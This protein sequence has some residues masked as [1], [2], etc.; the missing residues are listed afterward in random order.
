MCKPRELLLA[1][2]VAAVLVFAANAAGDGPQNDRADGKTERDILSLIPSG[3][4]WA[5]TGDMEVALK[6]QV[7]AKIIGDRTEWQKL[8]TLI[9][10][11]RYVP[12][13]V[14]K[15]FYYFEYPDGTWL[16]TIRL[17]IPWKT[18][19]NVFFDVTEAQ[20]KYV[21]KKT[22]REHEVWS[23]VKLDRTPVSLCYLLDR[24]LFVSNSRLT[25]LDCID[26]K[27]SVEGAESIFADDALRPYISEL[28]RGRLAYLVYLRR[29]AAAEKEADAKTEDRT[30]GL[31]LD[32]ES[33]IGKLRTLEIWIRAEHEN[34]FTGTIEMSFLKQ[35]AERKI[36]EFDPVTGKTVAVEYVEKVSQ[37]IQRQTAEI[38]KRFFAAHPATAE[39]FRQAL[40]TYTQ[41]VKVVI[42]APFDHRHL[43]PLSL[44]A[45][46]LWTKTRDARIVFGVSSRKYAGVA[47][48]QR[49][50]RPAWDGS[51]TGAEGNRPGRTLRPID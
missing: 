48:I 9:S 26:L 11:Y 37:E 51:D 15:R 23:G 40:L 36:V 45:I 43:A 39:Y 1:A 22:V 50:H 20:N 29:N 28:S 5:A 32:P 4:I 49:T 35:D 12:A 44:D 21:T 25:I 13:E 2:G 30:P 7:L 14:A 17:E 31:F 3:A 16:F 27:H 47:P 8:D 10:K 41:G 19:I 34:Q 24:Q 42:Q 18:A 6:N 46:D 38:A 33:F